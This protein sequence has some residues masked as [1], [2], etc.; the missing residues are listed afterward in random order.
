M[1][2]VDNSPSNNCFHRGPAIRHV[3]ISDG[4]CCLDDGL[5]TAKED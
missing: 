3:G 4:S 1:H 5:V 2:H